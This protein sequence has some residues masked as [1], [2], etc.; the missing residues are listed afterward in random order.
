MSRLLY[1]PRHGAPT[2]AL[3]AAILTLIAMLPLMLVSGPA[4]A[5]PSASS[6]FWGYYQLTDNAWTFA[7][8]GAEQSTPADGSV[9]GWRFAVADAST[10]RYPRA[11]A[12]FEQACGSVP[13]VENT[14]RVGVV[15]DY[16][17]P[18]DAADPSATPPAPRVAC[19]Q[20]PTEATGAQVLAAAADERIENGIVCGIDAYPAAGCFEDVA[21]PA[22]AAAAPDESVTLAAQ[23]SSAA[24]P[25]TT[26]EGAAESQ[27]AHP[28]SS[29]GP[30]MLTWVAILLTL[31]VIAAAIWFSIRRRQSTATRR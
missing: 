12:T 21:T 20:V 5:A 11:I 26:Q 19:S 17:R 6:R 7:S 3:R 15:I 28:E 16:G 8:T 31:L 4:T 10:P 29:A 2:S 23:P 30:G 22:P 9:E 27:D 24:Q 14:K 18:A 25:A 13:P 1:P